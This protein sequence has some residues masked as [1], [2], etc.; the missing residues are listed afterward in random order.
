MEVV[1]QINTNYGLH[2]KKCIEGTL[3]DAPSGTSIALEG[4]HPEG[5]ELVAIGHRHNSKVTLFFVITKNAESARAGKL[6]EMKFLGMHR[7]THVRLVDR[8]AVALEFFERSNSIDK[9]NQAR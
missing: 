1:Y 6:C 4:K 5:T 7:T 8:S 3:K 9:H 2:L